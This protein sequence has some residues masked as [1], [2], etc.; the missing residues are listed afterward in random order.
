MTV[1]AT[2]PRPVKSSFHARPMTLEDSA[3][4]ARLLSAVFQES[5]SA[6]EVSGKYFPD[7]GAP[8]LSTVLEDDG[9]IVGFQGHVPQTWRIDGEP[10]SAVM[11]ADQVLDPAYRR[12]DFFLM[13]AD[14]TL[15][16]LLSHGIRFL[17]G[18][19]LDKAREINVELLDF[20]CLG[21]VPRRVCPVRLGRCL[22]AKQKNPLL[23]AVLPLLLWPCDLRLIRAGSWR[24]TS[25]SLREIEAV[26][27]RYD[28]F[29]SARAPCARATLIRSGAEWNRR[30]AVE[31]R[32][33]YV[34]VM[35]EDPRTGVLMGLL[36]LAEVARDRDGIRMGRILELEVDGAGGDV[37]VRALLG[38]ALRLARQRGWDALDAW[39]S[40]GHTFLDCFRVAGFRSAAKAYREI[41]VKAFGPDRDSLPD[42]P[43]ALKDW[44][45]SLGNGDEC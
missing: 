11:G 10:V 20:T 18:V 12:L 3:A 32:T 13:M 5:R 19:P 2:I 42:F 31:A 36:V 37:V 17:W 44:H 35:A 26:D 41:Q 45:W 8:G 43:S 15:R 27:E 40:P 30:F 1:E 6:A 39:V 33:S 24:S 38:Y 23:R 28:R 25:L 14:E 16:N 34:R 9:Q 22:A 29:L 21:P 4:V 7:P